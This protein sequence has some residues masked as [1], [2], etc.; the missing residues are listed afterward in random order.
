MRNGVRADVLTFVVTVPVEFA[1]IVFDA[2]CT[3]GA[4]SVTVTAVSVVVTVTLTA[5]E[6]FVV[7]LKKS[8]SLSEQIAALM[9]W[10]SDN[11]PYA[12]AAVSFGSV[13]SVQAG[14]DCPKSALVDTSTNACGA[15]CGTLLPK[16]IT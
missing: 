9:V 11:G 4:V 14:T 15:D 13:A 1:A 2:L 7:N 6:A 5:P 3:F 10:L 16:T 12:V 8:V